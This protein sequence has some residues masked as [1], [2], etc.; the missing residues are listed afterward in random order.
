MNCSS[1]ITIFPLISRIVN[2]IETIGQA[3]LEDLQSKLLYRKFGQEN[4]SIELTIRDING[5][6]VINDE[7]FTDYTAYY[8]GGGQGNLVDS[9]DID[10][11]QVL[12]DYGFENGKYKLTFSFQRKLLVNTFERP[13]YISEISPSRTEIRFASSILA[14]DTFNNALQN[15][16]ANVNNA[17]FVKDVNIS[18]SSG[19]TGLVVN[20]QIDTDSGLIKLYDPLTV[21][22]SVNS[23]F[24]IYE[25]IINPLE[26]TID[27]GP[28]TSEDTGV[29]LRAPN[30]DIQFSQEYTVPSKF[31][32]YDDI[33]NQGAVTSS[34]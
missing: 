6:I 8:S 5:N 26:A 15:L 24:R 9:I 10:Y 12:K 2:S 20:T 18:F 33:L 1:L 30:F 3:D 4:D 23:S 32:T 19:E 27:L 16:I 29:E 17:S 14:E 22:I 25:E 21:N 31:R 13:F 11:I 34:F 7:Q 28:S